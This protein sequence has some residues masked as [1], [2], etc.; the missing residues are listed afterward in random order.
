MRLREIYR[1]LTSQS[2]CSDE[3]DSQSS[4]PPCSS[5]LAPYAWMGAYS[6]PWEGHRGG[7]ELLQEG[8]EELYFMGVRF[9]E[10]FGGIFGQRYHSKA[11]R[12]ISTQVGGWMGVG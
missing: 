12:F 8:E 1:N 3:S 7:G 10:R 9:R 6:S 4:S 5:A 2:G 11:V